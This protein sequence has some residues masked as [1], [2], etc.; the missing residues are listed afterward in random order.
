[1]CNNERPLRLT[2][3]GEEEPIHI[4]SAHENTVYCLKASIVDHESFLSCSSDH[5]GKLWDLYDLTKPK[6]TF[7][8]HDPI[9]YIYCIAD[10]LNGYV[11]T[12][13]SDNT[14][15]VYVRNGKVLHKLNGHTGCVRDIAPVNDYQFLSCGNDAVTKHWNANSGACL[16]TYS[17]HTSC[18][19][20]IS[21]LFSGSLAVSGG[22]DKTVRIWRNGA[23][24]QT[25]LLPA[26]SVWSVKL[27][28]NEDLVC[29]SSDGVVRIFTVNE[30]RYIDAKAME[31]FELAVLERIKKSNTNKQL[32]KDESNEPL[33]PQTTE[34]SQPGEKD[35]DTMIIKKNHK[36]LVYRWSQQAFQWKFVGNV[37]KD[38]AST[39]LGK[40]THNGVQYDYVFAVDIKKDVPLLKI[41]YNRGQD[42]YAVAQQFL[43]DNDLDPRYLNRVANFITTNVQITPI[44]NAE[45]QCSDPFIGGSRYVSNSFPTTLIGKNS[46]TEQS[47]IP[48]TS[49]LKLEQGNII[50]IHDKLKEFNAKNK[51]GME[52][53]PDEKLES[54]VKLINDKNPRT[55]EEEVN[56]LKSLLNWPDELVFPAL[57][58]AR[59]A[60]L[61]KDVNEMF[62]LNGIMNTLKRH[63]Q[64]DAEAPNQMLTYRLLANLFSHEAGE[65]FCLQCKNEVLTATRDLTKFD[66]KNNEVAVSTYILNLTV[67][68]N[69]YNDVL[70]KLQALSVIMK[71]L[72]I[73]KEPE[74]MF[75]ILVA[76]GSLIVGTSNATEKNG[77]VN[78]AKQ[79]KA[80]LKALT[81]HLNG[82]NSSKVPTKLLSVI[83]H[84]HEL[85]K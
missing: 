42:P 66:S 13:G 64:K 54:V 83:R 68:L 3:F 79:S 30:Q 80:V 74:A 55:I 45:S 65:Q 85:I 27:L 48:H 44:L 28:P 35:G 2:M 4:V 84:I 37:I 16:G 69:K 67:A 7:L 63:F 8:G 58:I 43:F 17:G 77:F 1:M 59:L 20:S 73:L 15:I 5:T 75:R 10:L 50:A 51:E 52:N 19:Y 62:C 9:S 57:D 81:I 60:V 23:L 34:L 21:T 26:E 33:S 18:I 56:N 32:E 70:G 41:P 39:S 72:E 49:Y 47:Y 11:V 71:L 12:G 38:E 25:I 24:K 36:V 40:A 82:L 76:L 78:S 14:V 6:S 22:A 53:I 61:R 46:N 29:G 31:K